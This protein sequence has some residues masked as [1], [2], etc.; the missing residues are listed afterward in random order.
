MPYPVSF[1]T[2]NFVARQAGW[3]IVDW[4]EGDRAT[5]A[6]YAPIETYRERF[7]ELLRTARSFG[8]DQVDIWGGH[9]N[10]EW[11]TDDHIA[12]ARDLLHAHDLTVASYA[13]WYGRDAAEFEANCRIAQAIGAPIL[14]GNTGAW[15]HSRNEVLELLERYDL[16]LAF[17]NHPHERTPQDMLDKI[18]DAP[19]RIGTAVDTGWWGT[20]GVP[21]DEAIEAL[22]ARVMH[23]HLKDVFE[24]GQH[25]SCRFGDGV[26]PLEG[27]LAALDRI[28]YQGGVSVEHEP[29]DEDP[30]DAL[31]DDFRILDGW[32]R[33]RAA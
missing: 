14:G 30:T 26:V 33:R 32:L 17:E 15:A 31:H 23:V 27:C 19:E 24:V 3:H 10:F 18:G 2:A 28:G 12:I 8:L 16:R 11:A 25:R 7:D 22:G 1:M 9:L 29:F 13:S 20:Q 5:N 21:A 4:G 6:W